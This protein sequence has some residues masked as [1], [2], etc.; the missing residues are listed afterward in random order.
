MN[1]IFRKLLCIAVTLLFASCGSMIDDAK[2]GNGSPAGNPGSGNGNDPSGGG[3][4]AFRISGSVSDKWNSGTRSVEISGNGQTIVCICASDGSFGF[5]NVSPGTYIL[6]PKADTAVFYPDKLTVAVD[7]KDVSGNNF[8]TLK[9]FW[10]ILVFNE[11][12]CSLVSMVS[13]DSGIIAAGWTDTADKK[14]D[15]YIVRYDDNGDKVWEKLIGGAYDDEAV[16]IKKL[17]DN[18]YLLANSAGTSAS[19]SGSNIRTIKM[20]KD[21][22]IAYDVIYGGYSIDTGADILPLAD[23]SVLV[24]GSSKS[25]S[26]YGD[27][28]SIIYLV[29]ASGELIL[30]KGAP[31]SYGDTSD[32]Y[33]VGITAVT[34]GYLI[35][36]N[37]T[38]S[39]N[40]TP[41]IFT[42]LIGNDYALL[43]RQILQSAYNEKASAITV[44]SSG[45]VYVAGYCWDDI[46]RRHSMCVI[47]LN[48]AGIFLKNYLY[49][50]PGDAECSQII[51][52]SD[53][54]FIVS[55][56]IYK[57][58][59]LRDIDS[60]YLR[61][62]A[63]LIPSDRIVSAND[64]DEKAYGVISCPAG[65]FYTLDSVQNGLVSGY[66]IK[67][68]NNSLNVK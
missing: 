13:C 64:S 58:T 50:E 23:G 30:N 59:G 18:Y 3:T 68:T 66:R 53:N 21:G 16:A 1:D 6:T 54:D 11:R 65:G 35:V 49:N 33:S 60:V 28:D 48:N 19:M 41:K 14:K 9:T 5:N 44:N 56:F 36:G 25:F 45:N 38:E 29:N 8:K 51:A 12:S 15:I 39:I 52:V 40:H 20:D 31:W 4:A 10:D 42:A 22:K 2:N 61:I 32:D 63:G 27:L 17:G 57:T 47:S 34:G 62:T 43:S 46:T 26:K 55:G 7:S 37:T 67:K 24:L